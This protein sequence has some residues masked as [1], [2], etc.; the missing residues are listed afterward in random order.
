MAFL[1]LYEAPPATFGLKVDAL[2]AGA[3]SEAVEAVSEAVSLL[4]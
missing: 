2:E 4:L 3:C 1:A